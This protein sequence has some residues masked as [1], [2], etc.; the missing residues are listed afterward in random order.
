M[1][2]HLDRIPKKAFFYWGTKEFPW[3]R[4]LTLETFRKYHPDWEMVLHKK[5]E[6]D[7][8][9]DSNTESYWGRVE[10]LGVKIEEMDVEKELGVNFPAKYITIYA[11]T[12]RYIVLDRFGGFYVDMDNLFFRSL[13]SMPFN[14]A[15]N[16]NF[17]TFILP[18]PYHHFVLGVPGASWFK[19]VTEKQKSVLPQDGD[20]FLDTTACTGWVNRGDGDKVKLLP[21]ITTEENFGDSGPKSP[22]AVCLNWHGSG[23]YGKYQ[24]VKENNYMT[25]D[26]PLAACVRYCLHGEMGN[27]NGIGGVVWIQRGG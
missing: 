11:D 12:Y 23:V 9:P 8:Y 22:D 6:L 27:K 4:Y 1:T 18:P 7:S 26:H 5:P 25:S 3:I 24:M 14:N 21:M 20:H 2:W 10:P 13:E 15:D 17:D 19:K 16:R